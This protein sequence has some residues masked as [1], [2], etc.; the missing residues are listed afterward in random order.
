MDQSFWRIDEGALPGC[1]IGAVI[2]LVQEGTT[3]RVLRD[4]TQ[5]LV[6]SASTTKQTSTLDGSSITLVNQT[7]GWRAVLSRTISSPPG[8]TAFCIGCGASLP[9]NAQFCATCGTRVGGDSAPPMET[10]SLGSPAAGP[11]SP[12]AGGQ[13]VVVTQQASPRRALLALGAVIF[14]AVVAAAGFIALAGSGSLTPQHTIS[15]SFD[16]L[17]T[18]QTF[19][20][21]QMVGSG[22]QGT[23][24]YADIVPGAQVTLKDGDG[25]TL[26]STQLSSGTGTTSS[27]TFT[28]SID[29]VPEVPFY[30]LEV[31]HRGA[32]TESL[33]QMQA[34]AWAFGLTLGK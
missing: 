6:L 13:P 9:P 31:S 23:G 32:I 20:S 2:A 28:F 10:T 14:V 18:D 3:A 21:I 26:G 22:C 27:C 34:D 7:E 8:P 11:A 5:V 17:A 12:A 15:G 25:K 1:P 24:G 4:G 19:P 29:N 33:A 30:S 16:V